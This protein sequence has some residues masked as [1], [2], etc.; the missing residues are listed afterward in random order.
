MV[1][2]SEVIVKIYRMAPIIGI[3][4]VICVA[5]YGQLRL[6]KK[7]TIDYSDQFS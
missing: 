1:R 2:S 3:A 5:K 7:I 6:E 4:E